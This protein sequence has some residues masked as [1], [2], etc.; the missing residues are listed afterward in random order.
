M[1]YVSSNL[2]A[3]SLRRN[4][5][6]FIDDSLVDLE[7]E[8]EA[9]VVSLDEDLR[10]LLHGLFYTR[11]RQLPAFINGKGCIDFHD[12]IKKAWSE[13]RIFKKAYLKML[14]KERCG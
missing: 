2:V 8:T 12:I 7:V 14:R 6:Y 13:G 1:R 5:R 3:Q 9:G 10:G 11:D 4:D